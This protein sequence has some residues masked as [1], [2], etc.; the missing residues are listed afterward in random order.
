MLGPSLFGRIRG[1]T[2]TLFPKESIIVLEAFSEFGH[3]MFLFFVGLELELSSFCRTWKRATCISFFGTLFSGLLGFGLSSFIWSMVAHDGPKMTFRL[4]MAA[5]VSFTAFPVLARILA[6]LKMLT[7]ELGSLAICIAALCDGFIWIL[8]A[9]LPHFSGSVFISS[10]VFITATIV[11]LRF[12]LGKIA[13]CCQ[14]DEPVRAGH[15]LTT[16]ISIIVIGII[17]SIIGI[18]ALFGAFLVGILVPRNGPFIEGLANRLED[19]IFIIILPLFFLSSGLKTDITSI[20]SGT[21]WALLAL[22]I[23]CA[24]V[25]KIGGT[26]IT[27]LI[28]KV[29]FREAIILGFLMN[30]KG[31]VEFIMLNI[32]KERQVL[33]D[34]MFAIM[35]LTALI[36]T[37]MTPPIITALYR[38]VKIE[39]LY[40]HRRIERTNMNAELRF[41]IC[42]IDGRNVPSL[43]SLLELSRG[44]LRRRL[45]VYAVHLMALS[46]RSSAISLVHRTVVLRP[47]TA[48]SKMDTIYKDII[49][50]A[51]QKH[52]AMIVLPFQKTTSEYHIMEPTRDTL[53]RV[54]RQ[55]ILD[56]P[57]SVGILVD[58]CLGNPGCMSVVVLFFGGS[59]D[60]EALSY[61]LL[62]ADRPGVGLRVLRFVAPPPESPDIEI[63]ESII[64][65]T[66]ANEKQ[67]DNE[68]IN[69]LLDRIAAQ[70][71]KNVEYAE[72]VV[73]KREIIAWEIA[74]VMKCSLFLVG[75]RAPVLPLV[76]ESQE[77]WELGPVGSLLLT[78]MGKMNASIMVIKQGED[79]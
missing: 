47:V 31:L 38:P 26:I 30:T 34:E 20:S 25:G 60:R 72:R 76:D 12:L 3:L 59:D 78:E 23:S 8:L 79:K 2:S 19:L 40:M 6:E 9:L 16:V 24:C 10:L 37:A 22:V 65:Q 75:L 71:V 17:S 54:S 53:T 62:M 41:L 35:V 48:I 1:F 70:M 45:K 73:E 67:K 39:G 32:G 14:N 15:V 74:G 58:H 42:F 69:K 49:S 46:D 18:Q 36:T 55:V 13:R 68:C 44:N 43:I 52:V 61:G 64:T 51:E 57:C 29:P 28:V 7:T 56:A 11:I 4:F 5:N 63:G 21:S 66:D 77:N 33:N 50:G 27:S